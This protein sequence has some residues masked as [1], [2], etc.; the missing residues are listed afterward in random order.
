MSHLIKK[1]SNSVLFLQK[2]SDSISSQQKKGLFYFISSKK[3]WFCSVSTK[4]NLIL[5]HLIKKKSH[6]I[7]I[8]TQDRTEPGRE[9]LVLV[10]SLC[11]QKKFQSAVNH[12]VA[13][14]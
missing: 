13:A 3:I 1:K 10:I 7:L 4:K 11:T 14:L 12:Y 5:S 8:L 6:L 2:K 9:I